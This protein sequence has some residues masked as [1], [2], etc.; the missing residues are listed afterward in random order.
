MAKWRKRESMGK[1]IAR[2]GKEIVVALLQ[3]QARASSD[4][5]SIRSRRQI[6]ALMRDSCLTRFLDAK[7]YPP[8]SK[9]L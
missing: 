2:E 5:D 3:L 6:L 7:R 8:R 4:S 9:T 1:T